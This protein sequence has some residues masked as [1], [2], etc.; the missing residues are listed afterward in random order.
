[1]CVP[2]ASHTAAALPAVAAAA[3]TI[4]VDAVFPAVVAQS[5]VLV[6]AAPAAASSAAVAPTPAVAATPVD[7]LIPAD[8]LSPAGAEVRLLSVP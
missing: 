5:L 2:P 6:G 8:A 7:A 4:S 3:P 1:M